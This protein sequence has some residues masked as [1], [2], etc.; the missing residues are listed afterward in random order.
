[1]VKLKLPDRQVTE[2]AQTMGKS[3]TPF[4]TSLYRSEGTENMDSVLRTVLVKVM[5]AMNGLHAP[6][7]EKEVKDAL[8]QMFLMKAPGRDGFHVHFVQ[9]TWDLCGAEVTSVVLRVLHGENNV[10]VINNTFI[11]LIPK[12]ASPEELG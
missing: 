2:D 10:A 3:M 8:F 7:S 9:C 12:V 5:A 1:M 4:Y 11:V 6:F